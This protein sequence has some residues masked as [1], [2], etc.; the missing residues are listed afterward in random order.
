MAGARARLPEPRPGEETMTSEIEPTGYVGGEE[1]SSS[2]P[3][4]LDARP[5]IRSL[6][7]SYRLPALIP[8]SQLKHP[9]NWAPLNQGHPKHHRLSYRPELC[10]PQVRSRKR[11]N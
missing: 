2:L 8:A 10:L 9:P 3:R 5:G 7:G 11:A 4:P 1:Q 6:G